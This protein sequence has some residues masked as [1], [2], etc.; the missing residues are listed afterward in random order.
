[1]FLFSSLWYIHCRTSTSWQTM[2]Q[3]RFN[4]S[5]LV[6]LTTATPTTTCSVNNSIHIKS[7]MFFFRSDSKGSLANQSRCS[8]LLIPRE[9]H[10]FL[11]NHFFQQARQPNTLMRIILF[12]RK[13]QFF[14]T[15][16]YNGSILISAKQGLNK[17]D[18]LEHKTN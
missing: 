1:M 15:I 4:F 11:H 13:Q 12:T 3:T 5:S 16:T 9:Q 17:T 10:S 14:M 6:I 8:E 18:M 7:N 2:C